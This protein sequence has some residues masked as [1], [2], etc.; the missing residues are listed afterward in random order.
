MDCS[1]L[2]HELR[3]TAT[4][5][6][7]RGRRN[8]FRHEQARR[9]SSPNRPPRHLTSEAD[10]IHRERFF[11]RFD[12]SACLREISGC[13]HSTLCLTCKVSSHC[14]NLSALLCELHDVAG[15]GEGVEGSGVELLSFGL[16]WH[17]QS[18]ERRRQ[19]TN[20]RKQQHNTTNTRTQGNE[21]AAT[22]KSA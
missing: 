20:K 13:I 14:H 3:H 2:S 6:R 19:R 16:R 11:Q 21:H 7:R 22:H 10:C 8:T 5:S 1:T 9:R 18:Q 4:Q 15:H 17:S 12:P